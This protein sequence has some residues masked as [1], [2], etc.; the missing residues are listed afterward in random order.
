MAVKC[1]VVELGHVRETGGRTGGRIA[2]LFNT[3]YR[4]AGR[5]TK[6]LVADVKSMAKA[7]HDITY[8]AH[9]MGP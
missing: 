6:L 7:V 3:P 1:A 5:I 8:W 9:S 4:R 2:A